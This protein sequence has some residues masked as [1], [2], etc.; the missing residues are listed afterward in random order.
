MDDTK[1]LYEFVLAFERLDEL[2]LTSLDEAPP[3][4]DNGRDDSKWAI[5]KWKP[6]AVATEPSALDELYDIL[7]GRFPPLYERLVLTYRW[8]DVRLDGVVR[9]FANP[10]GPSLKALLS[11]ITVDA[12]LSGILFH[13]GMIQF[14]R[15][16]DSYDPICFDTRRSGGNGDSPIIRVEHEAIL[17]DS[18]LGRYWEV[19]PS[20]RAFVD[21]GH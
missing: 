15:A 20:F 13:H 11:E 12:G 19:A 5:Q 7:P 21:L 8:L 3:E 1:L 4:L 9:L 14:G 6:A 10:P 17:C 18:R 16:P 2:T